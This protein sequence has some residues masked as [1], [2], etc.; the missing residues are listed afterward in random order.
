MAKEH[1]YWHRPYST[2]M[3][4]SFEAGDVQWFPE[5]GLNVSYNCVDR[6]AYK[7]P[8]KVRC[9]CFCRA[10]LPSSRANWLSLR[11][12]AIIWEADEPG[13]HVELTYEQ[14]LQEVCKT[15]NI[16]KSYGVKKG[17][18]SYLFTPTSSFRRELTPFSRDFPDRGHLLAHV[19]I[20]VIPW[21][22]A[23]LLTRL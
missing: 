13:Q 10:Q 22:F 15:A 4:G 11:Q 5:G 14:L 7:H 19:G 12:T 2:V 6:W 21:R 9:R 17:D 18:V 20:P 3:A 1:I 16:L 8:N 23:H